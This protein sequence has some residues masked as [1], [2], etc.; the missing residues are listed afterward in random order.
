MSITIPPKGE[1]PD[2]NAS[3]P[4][5][6]PSEP[7]DVLVQDVQI[8]DAMLILLPKDDSKKPLHFDIAQLNLKSVGRNSAMKY[9]AALTIPKPPGTLLTTGNFGPWAG[10]D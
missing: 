8:R 7:L 1:R 4:S 5:G 9:T 10:S 3:A 2:L 6:K